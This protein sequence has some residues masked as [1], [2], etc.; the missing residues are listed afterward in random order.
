MRPHRTLSLEHAS[1]PAL[2]LALAV[3]GCAADRPAPTREVPALA[4]ARD[5]LVDAASALSRA[6]ARRLVQSSWRASLTGGGGTVSIADDKQCLVLPG[7][8]FDLS[9]RRVHEGAESGRSDESYRAIRKDRVFFTRG[10]GGPFVRWDDAVDE[11]AAAEAA[12]AHEAR[13]LLEGLSPCTEVAWTGNSATVRLARVPCTARLDGLLEGASAE[14]RELTGEVRVGQGVL[15]HA[16]LM[17]RGLVSTASGTREAALTWRV[18]ASEPGPGAKVDAP[19][20]VSDGRRERPVRMAEEV[21][22]GLGEPWGPGAAGF[23][24]DPASRKARPGEG[25]D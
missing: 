1:L 10:S 13:A 4:P 25:E 23:V 11:P 18:D 9:V 17:L 22:G 14:L 24:R 16:S 19:A 7:G 12:L 21:L 15:L 6:D 20:D 5:P 2:M 8:D 3:S